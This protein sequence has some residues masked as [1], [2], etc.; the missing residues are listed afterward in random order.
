MPRPG[1]R[2]PTELELQ[3]LK[4]LWREGEC[5]VQQAREALASDEG[6]ELARTSVV[7]T[8]NI[9]TDKQLVHR[10]QH[11]KAYFFK[12]A[13]TQDDVSRNMLGDLLD[14]VF[15]G[16]AEALVLN[17]LQ[18][19]HVDDEEHLALRRLINRKRQSGEKS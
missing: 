5:S 18:S 2:H 15:D 12:P 10:R 8:L 9:M 7:T 6:R 3:I 11:G 4:I 1:S 16:S 19:E 14:R 13:A 17:L